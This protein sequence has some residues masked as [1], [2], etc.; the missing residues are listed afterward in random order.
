MTTVISLGGRGANGGDGPYMVQICYGWS[1]AAGR[2][3]YNIDYGNDVGTGVGLLHTAIHNIAGVKVVFGHSEGSQVAGRWMEAYAAGDSTPTDDLSFILL[4]N[5]ERKYGRP[6]WDVNY[7]GKDTITPNCKYNVKDVARIGD[8]WANYP[9]AANIFNSSLNPLSW[10]N[11]IAGMFLI[12]PFYHNVNLD[13][14]DANALA[15]HVEGNT[16]YYVVA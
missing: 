7:T 15:T 6:P 2:T 10:A 11:A 14:L 1:E 4:G 13:T 8:G 3:R 12:H 16:T 9:T 5:P